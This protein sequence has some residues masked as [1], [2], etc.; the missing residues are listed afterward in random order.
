MDCGASITCPP[1]PLDRVRAVILAGD[2]G[3]SADG[4]S[5]CPPEV[6]A[7][8]VR[9]F[10]A[11]VAGANV[12]ARQHGVAL[13]VLELGVDDDLEEVPAEV[14]A[15]HIGS[16]RPIDQADALTADDCRERYAPARRLPMWRSRPAPIC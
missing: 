2:H 12:L 4:V 5:A 8:M 9:A 10:V 16:S 11:G 13:R 15:Y 3:V 14:S 6:T 1:R 7:V